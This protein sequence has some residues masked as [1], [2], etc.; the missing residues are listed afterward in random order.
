MGAGRRFAGG[1]AALSVGA[2]PLVLDVG[3]ASGA[4]PDF[5]RS[6]KSFPVQY[7]VSG[8]TVTCGVELSISLSRGP[9]DPTYDAT[10][11]TA[12]AVTTTAA[13]RDCDALVRVLATYTD[14]DG[15]PRSSSSSGAFNSTELH[16]DE[17]AGDYVVE[18]GIQFL[19]CDSNCF[20][21]F[22]SAQPK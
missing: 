20:L 17:V 6:S 9:G 3:V 7:T 8:R 15:D 22:T 4:P 5:Y 13:P 11:R 12:T 1:I 14:E 18:H 21:S 16:L 10:A 19:S 2:L